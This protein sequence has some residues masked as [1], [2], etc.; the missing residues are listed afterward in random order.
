MNTMAALHLFHG[1][2]QSTS[3][4]PLVCVDAAEFP[5]KR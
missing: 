1:A 4:F 2:E 3:P 5:G